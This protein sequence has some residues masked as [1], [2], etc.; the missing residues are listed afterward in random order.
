MKI[1]EPNNTNYNKKTNDGGEQ[2]LMLPRLTE[3]PGSPYVTF[4][5]IPQ[6]VKNNMLD[7]AKF[8]YQPDRDRLIITEDHLTGKTFTVEQFAYHADRILHD[9]KMVPDEVPVTVFYAD[10]RRFKTGQENEFA[11]LVANTISDF[12]GESIMYTN[13]FY[14]ASIIEQALPSLKTIIELAPEAINEIRKTDINLSTYSFSSGFSMDFGRKETTESLRVYHKQQMLDHY[15]LD[16]PHN[17]IHHIVSYVYKNSEITHDSDGNEI[18]GNI[19][20]GYWVRIL[21]EL[22]G[23]ATFKPEK[24]KKRDGS[25]NVE[26]LANY[27][28][29]ENSD[30]FKPGDAFSQM[31]EAFEE[32]FGDSPH[33]DDP[34]LGGRNVIAAVK[35][36][37]AGQTQEQESKKNSSSGLKYSNMNTLPDRIK[38]HVIGQDEVV[39]EVSKGFKVAA[40]GLNDE[41]KPVRSM[42]ML[43]P[44]GVGKTQLARTLAEELAE[45]PMNVIR[46][47]MSEYSKEHDNHKLFG[48]PAGYVGHEKGGILTSQVMEHPHSLILLDEVEKAS[49]KIW[50]SFLQVLDAGRM[51]DSHGNIVDFQNTVIVMTSNLGTSEN[52]YTESGF[53]GGMLKMNHEDEMKRRKKYAMDM[54]KKSF[55]PEFINRIDDTFVFDVLPEEVL[56]SIADKELDELIDKV[57]STSKDKVTLEAPGD[58]V[59]NKIII[60]SDAKTY[61]ARDIKRVVKRKVTYLL[62]DA[63]LNSGNKRVKL[64]LDLDDKEEISVSSEK[65]ERKS[66]VKQRNT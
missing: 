50:D 58:N 6:A 23:E 37:A 65:T 47:D 63:I 26:K 56:K 40:S 28:L 2:E 31:V 44:T 52:L 48:A 66:A 33:G 24:Y 15:G 59:L 49:H 34:E 27:A 11:S 21:N 42:M 64:S 61:G 17:F 12:P 4:S 30:F 22:L 54:V 7:I 45:E 9:A 14:T 8:L 16:L 53:T 25:F 39:D 38:K 46:L 62:A 35:G 20:M 57:S 55:R 13:N 43:G 3:M 51:T 60:D 5:K 19:P 32:L 41:D 1:E 10:A 36:N 29:V 18:K